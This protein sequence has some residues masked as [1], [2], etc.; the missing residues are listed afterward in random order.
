MQLRTPSP[1]SVSEVCLYLLT[2]QS[3]VSTDSDESGADGVTTCT[4]RAFGAR[5]V[6][7]DELL[8]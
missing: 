8:P 6:E 3:L 2:G 4:K 7:Y 5:R 1:L